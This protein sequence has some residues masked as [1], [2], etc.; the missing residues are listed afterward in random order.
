M[1]S[2]PI[3]LSREDVIAILEKNICNFNNRDLVKWVNTM[4]YSVIKY[5]E[6]DDTF[7]WMGG[8]RPNYLPSVI[9]FDRL[10]KTGLDNE[11]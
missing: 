10:Q 3:P 9:D 6:E 1:G 8:D 7:V 11:E 4:T 5:L 2:N